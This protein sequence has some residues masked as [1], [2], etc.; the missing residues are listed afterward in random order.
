[1][2]NKNQ[3]DV[4]EINNAEGGGIIKARMCAHEREREKEGGRAFFM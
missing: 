4:N 2:E 3:W 1:M